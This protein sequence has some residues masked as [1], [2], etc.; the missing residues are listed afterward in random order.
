MIRNIERT[1]EIVTALAKKLILDRTTYATNS[2]CILTTNLR[3]AVRCATTLNSQFAN[4]LRIQ[5]I[6]PIFI[7][8]NH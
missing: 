6:V 1:P 7:A 5:F 8:S 2:V 3:E 4:A